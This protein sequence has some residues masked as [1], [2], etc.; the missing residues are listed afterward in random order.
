MR[1]CLKL[2]KITKT[3]QDDNGETT[4]IKDFSYD[5]KKGHFTSIIG[6]SG[7]GKSTLLSV[8][9]GLEVPTSGMI[10]LDNSKLTTKNNSIGYMLQKDY[11]LEFR[12]VYKNILI[13]LEIKKNMNVK[14]LA[15]VD[16]LLRK[17]GLFEFKDK[18]PSQLSGGMR[19]RVA[20]IRTLATNPDIL[21][22][23]EAF[24]ALDYQ[25]RLLVTDDVYQIIRAENKTAIMVTH[26]IPESISMSDEVI[27]LTKRPSTISQ[28]YQISFDMDDRTPLK[29]REHPKFTTYFDAIWQTLNG[30]TS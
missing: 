17:Y 1:D 18:Y 20:L 10:Y 6:P 4:A 12:T 24:S 25:T 16:A 3:Y 26:D 15:Y 7:C 9:C 11:L 13:G 21:L 8:I 23:D 19:Q 28:V 2:E 5:F 29:C 27:V 14:T 22:L 30:G